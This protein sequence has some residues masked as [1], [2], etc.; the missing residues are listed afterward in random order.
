MTFDSSFSSET[1]GI[2]SFSQVVDSVY[3]IDLRLGSPLEKMLQFEMFV[4]V[5]ESAFIVI[6]K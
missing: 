2:V 3:F 6:S 4:C 1:S 5:C